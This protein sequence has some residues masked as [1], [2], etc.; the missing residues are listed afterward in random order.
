MSV[1]KPVWE[2]E[3][4]TY[5]PRGIYRPVRAVMAASKSV[6]SSAPPYTWRFSS[7]DTAHCSSSSTASMAAAAMST[8]FRVR[9]PSRRFTAF[10]SDAARAVSS[11]SSGSSRAAK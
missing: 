1:M 6:W 7:G 3:L 10:V 4:P 2:R 5:T 9:R 8:V 11:G